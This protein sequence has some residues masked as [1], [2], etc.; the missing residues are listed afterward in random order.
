MQLRTQFSLIF[1]TVISVAIIGVSSVLFISF[2]K[3][4]LNQITENNKT[5][6]TNLARICKESIITYDDVLLLNYFTTLSKTV[7]G[8]YFIAFVDFVRDVVFQKGKEKIFNLQEKSEKIKNLEITNYKTLSGDITEFSLPV[9]LEGKIR[10]VAK[11]GI[12][13][14][15]INKKL[16]QQVKKVK[17]LLLHTAVIFF[18]FGI[19][20]ALILSK[21]IVNPI[22]KLTLG[23]KL[24]GEGKLDTYIDINLNNEI[25]FL[26]NE[27][28]Q[29]AT[30]LKEL[31]EMKDD[32]IN[33][34]SHELRSPLSGIEGYID[35]LMSKPMEEINEE[36]R[37]RALR[38]IKE[39]SIRLSNFITNI[40]DIAKIKAGKIEIIK[41]PLDLSII[42]RSV[43][44]LYKPI[45]EK[46][47]IHFSLEIPTNIKRVYA[48][49]DKINQVFNNLI[50]NAIKFTPLGGKIT[51]TSSEEEHFIKT[52]VKDTGIGI[53]KEEIPYIFDKFRQ[54]KGVRDKITGTKGTGLG[55]AIVK[56]IV[57]LNGG[58]I[59]VESELGKGSN[60]IF[61]LPIY[62]K[63]EKKDISSG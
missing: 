46:K 12:L 38:I 44:E 40:L 35:L 11:I 33:S 16:T 58:K 55:L 34:V 36:K 48:D 54:V 56:S 13:Q 25:G 62:K 41:E 51:I 50:G 1:V 14:S 47:D 60:F 15:V 29:M 57:E 43:Y 28:N 21:Q 5:L 3:I 61:T 42:A 19:I 52:E 63:D 27:F 2:R 23:A 32:F 45:I 6:V 53:S 9:M 26:A 49:P 10:G 39:S 31:D 24:I 7:E 20:I 17:R 59:W 22:S 4:L 8:I 18:I 37:L 30:K